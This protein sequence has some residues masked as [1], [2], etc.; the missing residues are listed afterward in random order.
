MPY[1]TPSARSFFTGKLCQ[2]AQFS[3]IG[4]LHLFK[5]GELTVLQ[6]GKADLEL[7]EPTLLFYPRGRTHSFVVDPERG[8]DLVCATVELGGAEGNPIGQGRTR[9][10]IQEF[11]GKSGGKFVGRSES[12]LC[13]SAGRA[14]ERAATLLLIDGDHVL[15]SSVTRSGGPTERLVPLCSL[16][17]PKRQASG[18]SDAVEYRPIVQKIEFALMTV[19]IRFHRL[20]LQVIVI[21]LLRGNVM[22]RAGIIESPRLPFSIGCNQKR[23]GGGGGGAHCV[24][25]CG[26]WIFLT[27]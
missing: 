12:L 26:G 8:A 5:A 27:P 13:Q 10:C 21:D 4:H 22:P 1:V 15:S 17:I 6:A 16:P 20:V 11:G 25:L 18:D 2:T 23:K 9:G 14:L 24:S 19:K 7:H 3:D